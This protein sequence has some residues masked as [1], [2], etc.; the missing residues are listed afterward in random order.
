MKHGQNEGF[1]KKVYVNLLSGA[2]LS[3]NDFDRI[4]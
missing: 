3:T 1:K 4:V 2:E